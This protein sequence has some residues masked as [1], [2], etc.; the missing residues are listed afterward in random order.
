MSLIE[1]GWTL[2]VGDGFSARTSTV[3]ITKVNGMS[4]RTSVTPPARTSNAAE[5]LEMNPGRDAPTT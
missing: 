2:S 3:G 1:T 5:S 4:T